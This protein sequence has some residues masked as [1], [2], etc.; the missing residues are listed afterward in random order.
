MRTR[1]LKQAV[2]IPVAALSV[3]FGAGI[4]C[5]T[6]IRQHSRPPVRNQS[7]VPRQRHPVT[8]RVVVRHLGRMG[9]AA[10]LAS[11]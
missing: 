8:L 2:D 5:R 3:L 4:P 9:R 7:D 10:M 6:T 1:R 11:R